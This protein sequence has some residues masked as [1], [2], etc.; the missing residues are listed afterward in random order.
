[1]LNP[2][3]PPGLWSLLDGRL[4]HA[5]GPDRLQGMM[6]DG[7][8]RVGIGNRYKDS[9]CRSQGGVCLFDF[10]P[11]AVD[12]PGQFR[13]WVEWFGHQQGTRIAVWLE[14]NRTAAIGNLWD[15]ATA[16]RRSQK[17]PHKTFI[18]GV[19]ACHKGAIPLALAASVLLI[20]RDDRTLFEHCSKLDT[21]IPRTIEAFEL[22]V[23]RTQKN[24]TVER[25][26][27]GRQRALARTPWT[28]RDS[29]AG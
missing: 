2:G 16:C 8:I 9:F 13:N 26:L 23:P 21:S 7:Q 17:S 22:K 27:A 4:W 15:A 28:E 25:L 1:M 10:G 19:E 24:T 3:L 18:P 12:K 5:T 14:I 29:G 20:A 11:T 6:S